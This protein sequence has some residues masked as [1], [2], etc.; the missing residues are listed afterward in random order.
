MSNLTP[1][2]T[3][4]SD[5]ES[6]VADKLLEDTPLGQLALDLW[7]RRSEKLHHDYAIAGWA[8]S[9]S[10]EVREH[11]S[12]NML[13]EHREAIERV[14]RHLH[15]VP[16]PNKD[17]KVVGA[18][19]DDVVDLFWDE[20]KCFE[21]KTKPFDNVARWNTQNVIDGKSYL[22]HEKYSLPYTSVLGYVA[23][24]VTSKTLGI[25]PCERNWASVKNIKTGKRV[26]LGGESLEKRSVLYATALINDAR[27]RRNNED[28]GSP[29][30]NDLF[31]DD[32]LK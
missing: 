8:L 11:V 32:D 23:C 22:W 7:N 12:Q 5:E 18:D 16:C 19:V 25:G 15:V 9:V 14:V 13:P 31:C 3:E 27:L 17:P 21:K 2:E 26:N 20:F 24:R 30:P 4:S 10:Q 29:G 6:E 28:M 1:H